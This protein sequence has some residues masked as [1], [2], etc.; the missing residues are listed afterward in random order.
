MLKNL[1]EKSDKSLLHAKL[2]LLREL[3][4]ISCKT[5]YLL[6]ILG[7]IKLL[8]PLQ[9]LKMRFNSTLDLPK[10]PSLK[11][12]LKV[13]LAGSSITNPKLYTKARNAPPTLILA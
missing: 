6:T 11:M 1:K 4:L 7:Q 10:D 12:T 9:S 2:T 8:E 5:L 3:K 13:I